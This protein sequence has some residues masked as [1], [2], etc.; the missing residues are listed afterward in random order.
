MKS[1]ETCSSSLYNTL[2][3]SIPP[4]RC[5]R[6]VYTL[7]TSLRY[8]NKPILLHLCLTILRIVNTLRNSLFCPHLYLRVF[9]D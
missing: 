4:Y 3:I 2:K 9:N 7:Q 6:Q 8:S 1:A 5:V